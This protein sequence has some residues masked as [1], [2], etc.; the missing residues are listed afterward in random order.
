MPVDDFCPW[1]D[2]LHGLLACDERWRAN[3]IR[4]VHHRRCY[5]IVRGLLRILLGR[6]MGQPAESLQ[7]SYTGEGKPSL[8]HTGGDGRVCFNVSHCDGMAA[9]ALARDREVGIDIEP[10]GAAAIADSTAERFVSRAELTTLREGPALE[11]HRA[12]LTRW[13]RL[14]ACLK[15]Q[16]KGVAALDDTELLFRGSP[17]TTGDLA[18]PGYAAAVAAEGSDWDVGCWGVRVKHEFGCAHWLVSQGVDSQPWRAV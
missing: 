5:V 15:A 6:Y 7:F 12:I 9:L 11:R 16:G 14:E 2:R 10:L 17:W 8:V 4:F 13:V 3:R 1:A 18:V